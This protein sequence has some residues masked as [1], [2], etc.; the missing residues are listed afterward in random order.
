MKK[1]LFSP[2]FL[3]LGLSINVSS[4]ALTIPMLPCAAIY[5]VTCYVLH[6]LFNTDL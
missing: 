4:Y 5:D 3:L 6:R 2:Y 1:Y